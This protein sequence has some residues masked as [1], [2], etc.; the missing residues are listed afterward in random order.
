M[1]EQ[2]TTQVD[3]VFAKALAKRQAQAAEQ[4]VSKTTGI[5]SATV[6]QKNKRK[7]SK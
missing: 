7:Q 5:S 3:D 4:E 1:T 6:S 2:N